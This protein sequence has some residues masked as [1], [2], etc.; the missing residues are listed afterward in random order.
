M[1]EE[2]RFR[3]TGTGPGLLMKPDKLFG[4]YMLEEMKFRWQGVAPL[5]HHNIEL[6]NPQYIW[7]QRIKKITS[8]RKKTEEDLEDLMWLEWRGG[9]YV[10][11][12]E[13]V[14][15]PGDVI[16]GSVTNAS[17]AF[18]LGPKMKSGVFEAQPFFPLQYDGPKE[19]EKLYED[20][21]FVFVKP[22]KVGMSTV[23]RTRPIFREWSIDIGLMVN[24]SIIDCDQV[25]DCVVHA[26]E[27][28]GVG[29]WHPRHGRFLVEE[30]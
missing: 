22:A 2:V 25:R 14:G 21:R 18:R 29:D 3:L 27:R 1:M 8:K 4:G 30:L 5:I 7:T 28:C 17:K 11:S 19:L 10:D 13:T 24:T 23:M 20:K 15:L 9:L 16:L 6:V 12:K 26:G